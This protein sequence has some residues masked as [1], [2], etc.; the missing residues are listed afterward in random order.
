MS[1]LPAELK[2]Y[3]CVLNPSDT[4]S[5]LGG[6][7]G[8]A[9]VN[10][11]VGEVFPTLV[12]NPAGGST[13]TRYAKVFYLN[14]SAESL[15]LNTT[16][17][18]I[19]NSLDAP[20]SAD[21]VNFLPT[22]GS[23]NSSKVARVVG[24]NAASNADFEDAV[25]QGLSGPVVTTKQF[26]KISRIE[27][28]QNNSGR[29]LTSLAGPMDVRMGVAGGTT[30]GT[31]PGG[32]NYGIGEI[33]IGLDLAL[34]GNLQISNSLTPP[35]G[36]SFSRPRIAASGLVLPSV[37]STLPVNSNIGIWIRINLLAG[38]NNTTAAT[39]LLGIMGN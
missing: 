16:Y 14:T 22:S 34:N 11:V 3:K 17:I 1:I 23:D 19:A 39:I 28:R 29:A 15:T 26:L 24:L 25:L 8:V 32:A 12:A 36:I 18:W 2:L 38:L 27:I 37:S 30:I 21:V 4:I 20:L 31:I 7:I 33:D 13:I 5:P 10:G 6:A 35:A 9:L